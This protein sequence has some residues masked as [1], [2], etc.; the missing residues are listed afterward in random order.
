[1]HILP[2]DQ[3]ER[4]IVN[5]QFKWLPIRVIDAHDDRFPEIAGDEVLIDP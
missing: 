5:Q 4:A 1:M 2:N 3:V